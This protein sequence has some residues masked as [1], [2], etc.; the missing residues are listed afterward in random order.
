[1]KKGDLDPLVNHAPLKMLEDMKKGRLDPLVNHAPQQSRTPII[2]KKR[3]YEKKMFDML[4]RT[5]LNINS[6][7]PI[8]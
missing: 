1:M 2:L 7:K 6:Y 5:F 3:G 8:K 4:K